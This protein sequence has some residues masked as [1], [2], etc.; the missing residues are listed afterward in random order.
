[1]SLLTG[2][3][4]SVSALNYSMKKKKEKKKEKE[5]IVYMPEVS[6]FLLKLAIFL[7]FFS[8]LTS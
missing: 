2:K 4:Y 7:L 5:Q 6:H 1:M 3:Y 8:P